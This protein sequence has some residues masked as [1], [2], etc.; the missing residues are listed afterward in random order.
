VRK[1]SNNTRF[2]VSDAALSAFSV[3]FTQ[4]PS[5]LEAARLVEQGDAGM[6]NMQTVF[7][8][9]QTPSDNQIRNLPHPYNFTR[10]APAALPLHG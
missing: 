3:F 7:G 9:H 6:S 2:A 10:L 5:L 4:C 8:V 1:P